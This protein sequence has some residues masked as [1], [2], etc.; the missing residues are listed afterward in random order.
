[1]PLTDEPSQMQGLVA[2]RF[3]KSVTIRTQQ[4]PI[5]GSVGQPVLGSAHGARPAVVDLQSVTEAGAACAA[6]LVS[7]MNYLARLRGEAAQ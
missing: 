6:A 4:H 1:M 7:I 5:G 2:M 3:D